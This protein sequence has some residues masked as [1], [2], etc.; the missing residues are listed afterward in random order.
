MNLLSRA[1]PKDVIVCN[2]TGCLEVTTTSYPNTAW[3]VPWIH[4]AFET[5]SA[6]ASGVEAALKKLGKKTKVLA[7]AGDGGTY[8]IGFQGLSGMLERGHKVTQI[9][10]DNE[11]YMNTGI[12]RSGSTPHGAWT[13]TSPNGKASIGKTQWKKPLVD[14]VAA[15]R[16]PY[17]ATASVGYPLDFIAKVKKALEKQPSFIVVHCNCPPG[18]KIDTEK[19][20]KIAKMAVDSGAW[21]LY[22]IED[23]KLRLTFPV[24]SRK[25]VAE[26]LKVQGR[27]KHLNEKDV[28]DIQS[29][30]DAYC[31]EL[32]AKEKS[33]LILY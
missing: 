5:V 23:G 3:Q 2:A 25:P 4:T 29:H 17:V 32:E 8:D 1:V 11:A 26:Y 6:T 18:W 33:G 22:E 28:A 20:P 16:I 24:K 7:I 14:I 12:Q 10:V 13:S 30:I 19:G 15:H 21:P 9:C 27:F 31:R